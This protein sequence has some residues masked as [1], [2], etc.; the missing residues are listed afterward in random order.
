[1]V[2]VLIK[3]LPVE[4]F[5]EVSRAAP[6]RSRGQQ[7]QVLGWRYCKENHQEILQSEPPTRVLCTAP[8]RCSCARA[9]LTAASWETR[10]HMSYLILCHNHRLHTH[11][12][13]SNSMFVSYQDAPMVHRDGGKNVER[14]L[15]ITSLALNERVGLNV[16]INKDTDTDINCT[17]KHSMTSRFQTCDVCGKVILIKRPRL[18]LVACP[19]ASKLFFAN[20]RWC[21]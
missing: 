1:M 13:S 20:D 10:S 3:L 7:R 18:Y 2:R 21:P 14:T 9:F 16:L 6:S 19:S 12:P 17:T 11:A 8:R 15:N 4:T 5:T